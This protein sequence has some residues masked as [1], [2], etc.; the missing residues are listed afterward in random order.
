M[1]PAFRAS[2]LQ[3]IQSYQIYH[4]EPYDNALELQKPHSLCMYTT[5]IS[6]RSVPVQC[7]SARWNFSARW[8]SSV[9]QSTSLRH[10]R[11]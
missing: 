1:R 3:P 2:V 7:L 11:A 6:L 10:S 4:N 9:L 8:N 5:Y